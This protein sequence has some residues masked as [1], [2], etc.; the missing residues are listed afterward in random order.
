MERQGLKLHIFQEKPP[1]SDKRTRSVSWTCRRKAI[2]IPGIRIAS[3][4]LSKR[5][6]RVFTFFA[7]LE[8]TKH[9]ELSEV[10]LFK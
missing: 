8:K 3:T 7:H 4:A 5:S 1:S 2:L 10:R 9:V 6:K